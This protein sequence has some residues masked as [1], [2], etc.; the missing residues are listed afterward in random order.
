MNETRVPRIFPAFNGQAGPQ[1]SWLSAL[2]GRNLLLVATGCIG[3][4]YLP[5]WI[6]WLREQAPQVN[7]KVVVTASA[8]EFVAPAPIKAFLGHPPLVDS[9]S[10]Q[11]S[12]ALHIEIESWADCVLVHPASMSFVSKLSAGLCDSPLLLALQGM[13]VP[14]VVSAAAPPG[15]TR[16]A[17]WHSYCAHLAERPNITLLEPAKGFSAVDPH[18]EGNPAQGFPLALSSLIDKMEKHHA[19]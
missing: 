6:S 8:S 2:S 9:W 15:F 7:L 19:A 4:M 14:I 17:A 10:H 5:M 12:S 18:R 1:E 3:T 13:S 11:S 16:S